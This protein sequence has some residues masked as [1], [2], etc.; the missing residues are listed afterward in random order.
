ML[1][2]MESISKSFAGVKAL[3]NVSLQVKKGE[4]LGLVGENGAGKSTLMK[5]LSGAYTSDSGTIKIDGEIV[6]NIKPS[7]M[8]EKGVGVI[9]QE[10]MLAPHMSVAENIFLGRFP[11]NK[12]GFIHYERMEKETTA[13]CEMLGLEL[14]PKAKINELSIAKRQMVEI[15]KALSREAK[16]IVLDEPTAVLGENELRGMFEVVR[17]LAKQGVSFIYISH[18]LKEIFDLVDTVI[19]LKDGTVVET[20]NI[21]NYNIDR[22][23]KGMVGRELLD[24][25]PRRSRSA[26]KEVLNIRGMSRKGVLQD[27]DLSLREG[28]IVAISGLAGSGRTEILK[29]IMGEDPIDSGNIEIFGKMFDPK[30]PKHAIKKGLGL[31]P[32]DRKGEGLFL[33]QPVIANA[34][35]ANFGEL[36]NLLIIRL[37]KERLKVI[38]YIDKIKIR[39]GNPD[40]EVRHLSGGNQQK[41]VFSKWLHAE[42]KI[43]LVDE[44]T[45]GID[46]G[47]KQEIY[48]LLDELV[49]RGMSVLMVSSELPEVLGLSDRVLVMHQGCI[50][51]ELETASTTEE[52]IMMYATGQL[53]SC[54]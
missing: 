53:T 30:S 48:F 26:G 10:L 12:Y 38:E 33:R 52:Q 47:A 2:E 29:S 37:G 25:F 19:I 9:Y 22:L 3:N 46:V 17:R 42:C 18:R 50:V 41:V 34:T 44:P 7:K 39:P 27:I 20:D 8:I 4:I 14:D 16:I 6:K 11:T 51:K 1:L 31:I 40:M 13:L 24:I 5:I 32:E 36:V 54:G 23:V 43:L 49:K 45:R 15:A 35:I 21:D 28:E